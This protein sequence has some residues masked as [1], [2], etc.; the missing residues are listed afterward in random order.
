VLKLS[1]ELLTVLLQQ[2]KKPEEHPSNYFITYGEEG[3]LKMM[4]RGIKWPFSK[5]F[6]LYA[7]FYIEHLV[8]EDM[9][10]FTLA[11]END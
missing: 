11:I 5:G 4:N 2:Q 6:H 1:V 7:K 8:T 9:L 10:L 3:G